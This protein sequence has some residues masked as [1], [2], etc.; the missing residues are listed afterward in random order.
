MMQS[1]LDFL[2]FPLFVSF[3]APTTVL[4]VIAFVA[5]GLCVWAISKQYRWNYPV[6][7]VNAAA[8][9]LLFWGVGLYADAI[10]QVVFI[11]LSLYGFFKWT[12][13][14]KE[15]KNSLPVV[16]INKK[17]L[18]VSAPLTL[19]AIAGAAWFLHSNTTSTV[20][21][22]D[23]SIL[24]LSLLATWFQTKK[25]L[26]AWWIWIVVDIIS[27]PLY[28]YKGLALT[29]ILYVVFLALCIQGLFAWTKDL[30]ARKA[31]KK[32]ELD[33]VGTAYAV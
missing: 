8:F 5:G 24:V 14:G 29:G 6:A 11:I 7:I 19:I 32:V 33:E 12:Y 13:G 27:I 31:A 10:L 20:Y 17:E 4:E 1:I 25:V 15:G 18:I 26:E 21:I 23:A 22:A 3:G 9:L 2:N 16:N 30:N 28:F